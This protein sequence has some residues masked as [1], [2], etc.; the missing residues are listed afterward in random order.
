MNSH[1]FSAAAGRRD[2]LK[3]GL[4]AAAV[5]SLGAGHG[6]ASTDAEIVISSI[7]GSDQPFQKVVDA[8]N[9]KGLGVTAVN[10]FDGNYEESAAK[11]LTSIAAGRA[12]DMMITGWKF[13][14]F[15]RR[16][17]GARDFREIDAARADAIISNFVPS[18][19]PLVTVDGALIGLPW[20]MST[21]VTW[22]NLA[23]WEEAGL[24]PDIPLDVEHDWLLAQSRALDE[25]LKARRHATYRTPLD[26]SNN[27]WT[28]QAYIQNAGGHIIDPDG[29]VAL[30]SPEAALGMTRFAEPA[31][32]GL[33]TPV[34]GRAQLA[35]FMSGALAI[36]VTSSAGASRYN[37]AGFP[38]TARMFPRI[39]DTRRMN[40]GGNFLAI[41][42]RDDEP[43]QAAMTFLEY[44]ASA[45]GQAI[46][47]EVGYLNTSVHEVPLMENHEAAARQLAEGLTAETIWPGAR[48]LEAQNVWRQY[49][50]RILEQRM[51]VE[52]ALAAAKRDIERLIGS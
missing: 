25:T 50:A 46:W 52:P 34:D 24:D 19:H 39:R 3:S 14:Y 45:E 26:L 21:P 9:A 40:S 37:N 35:A 38:V 31:H 10:R 22:I 11:A 30:D 28:S 48:G 5:L 44:A 15:A 32:E 20:A 27:E 12:P 41:Y 23:L 4:A 42:A 1:R 2:V 6:R 51:E 17:L 29:K 8:F 13:G 33:W 49:V 43:A 36:T 16:T 18:V 47:S 7:W